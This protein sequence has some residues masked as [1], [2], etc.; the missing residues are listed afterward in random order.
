MTF[1]HIL[2]GA[3][4]ASVALTSAAAAGPAATSVPPPVGRIAKELAAGGAKRVIVFASVR[5]KSYVAAAGTRRPKADQRFRVGSVTKTFTATTVLQLVDE[6]KLRLGDTLEDHLPG[7]VPRGNE[8]TIRQLLQHQS[9]LVNYTDFTPWL[10]G[11]SRSPSTRPIDLVRFAASKPLVFAP[12][13]QWSYSNTNYIALGLVIEQVTGRSYADELER[14]IFQ[15]L[16]LDA[17]ELPQTRLLP[18][19]GDDDTASLLPVIR[20]GDPYYDVDWA[21][22][23]ISWAAG[24][25]VSNAR[26]LARFYSAL[27][28]GG[29]LSDVS[30]GRMKNTVAAGHEGGYGLGIA[31]IGVRCGRKWGHGGGILDYG[32]LALASDKGER[33]GVT[34][35]YGAVP[36]TPPDE[37][38]LVCP[39]YRLAQSAAASTIA[40]LRGTDLYVTNGGG[41]RQQRL[42]RGD[43]PAWSPDGRKI[44]FFRRGQI[45]AM[46]FDGSGQRRL[47]RGSDPA[48]SPDGRSIAFLRSGGV[49]VMNADGSAQRKL[50]LGSAPAWSPDGR[51]ISFLRSDDIYVMKADGSRQRNLTR[52][53]APDVDP[54]WSPDGRRI[55]FARKISFVGGV[56]GNFE[57][58]V[59]NADG[60]G[61][62][63]LTREAA[64]DDAPAWSP[65]GRKITFE[66]RASSGGGGH[67]WAWFVVAVVNADGSG[68]PKYLSG[69]EPLRDR[70]PRAARPLWSPDGRMIAYLG[71]RH[72]NY[73]V[74]VMNADGSGLTNVTWSKANESS[75]AWSPRQKGS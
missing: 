2:C 27:L 23:V 49:Y 64:R 19:L 12:G 9:G 1:R 22:P 41:G 63:R 29:I 13:T 53:T 44:A 17:T 71:W 73:D 3:L 14:R 48:W 46:N 43:A 57:I 62:R 10:K 55:A 38:A 15:P 8:I 67:S 6:G 35:V 7:V 58:F 51:K 72:G 18:D 75:F 30:L 39:E 74:Y 11:A 61:Q 21:N 33:V 5:G 66:S 60:S 32:T 24:G 31:S 36:D 42:A 16:E 69:G 56:G 50:A 4:L 68:Q 59:M 40:F 20:K 70:A 47:A 37:S 52:N 28:S 34:S 54:A 45:Y 65:D 25:I 26:D